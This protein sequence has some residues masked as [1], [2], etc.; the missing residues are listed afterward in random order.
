MG[1]DPVCNR[2]VI[3]PHRG[4]G[5]TRV[6]VAAMRDSNSMRGAGR[7]QPTH[8]CMH[9]AMHPMPHYTMF[10]LH[11]VPTVLRSWVHGSSF[12]IAPTGPTALFAEALVELALVEPGC[13]EMR[14]SYVASAALCAALSATKLHALLPTVILMS[15]W[16][17]HAALSA[18]AQVRKERGD[19]RVDIWTHTQTDIYTDGTWT[20]IQM[21]Q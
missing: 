11:T 3:I 15:K 1:H 17:D 19:R 20:N 4:G 7:H 14:P 10:V 8:A 5:C 2:L 12:Q 21:G 18:L 6:C 13:A 16:K 9:V